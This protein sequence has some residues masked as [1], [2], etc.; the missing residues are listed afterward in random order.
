MESSSRNNEEY[1]AL[2]IKM[3]KF[4]KNIG[5]IDTYFLFI[6]RFI[7]VMDLPDKIQ[8]VGIYLFDINIVWP[9]VNL[10]YV[11]TYILFITSSVELDF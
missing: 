3:E 7:A 4:N 8:R 9:Y 11:F 1:T 6:R 2:G 10:I 5:S